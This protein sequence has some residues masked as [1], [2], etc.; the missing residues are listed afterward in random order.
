[1]S[2]DCTIDGETYPIMENSGV[3]WFEPQAWIGTTLKSGSSACWRGY[4]AHYRLTDG[5]L[6]LERVDLW[7]DAHDPLAL[8]NARSR[9]PID[10][11]TQVA[12]VRVV[13]SGVLTLGTWPSFADFGGLPPLS[14]NRPQFTLEFRDGI[15][16]TPNDSLQGLLSRWRRATEEQQ[17]SSKRWCTW[18]WRK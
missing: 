1:M 15:L 11:T 8:Q 13:V 17:R 12:P 6:T 16:V 7:G 4:V 9:V 14:D 18:K 10:R 2:D 3:G 5:A